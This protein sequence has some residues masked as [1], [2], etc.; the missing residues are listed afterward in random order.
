MAKVDLTTGTQCVVCLEDM[1]L[2]RKPRA[3][4][5]LHTLCHD[6]IVKMLQ[7]QQRNISGLPQAKQHLFG[8]GGVQKQQCAFAF[9][10]G[11]HTLKCPVCQRVTNLPPSGVEGLPINTMLCQIK[12]VESLLR[13]SDLCQNCKVSNAMKFCETCSKRLCSECQRRHDNIPAFQ[14]HFVRQVGT[15]IKLCKEHANEAEYICSVCAVQVCMVCVLS[16][17]HQE[18]TDKIEK[19]AKW[20]S[21]QR[22][23]IKK[24]KEEMNPKWLNVQKYIKQYTDYDENICKT[25][26]Q[27]K[28]TTEKLKDMIQNECDDMIATLSEKHIAAAGALRQLRQLNNEAET[29]LQ[30][31]DQVVD[32]EAPDVR[33]VLVLTDTARS[34]GQGLEQVQKLNTKAV[35][36]VPN[37]PDGIGI[38][39]IKGEEV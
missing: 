15:K 11:Q 9:G 10:S 34:F 28:E 19:Y 30:S 18:H 23:K 5:C 37:E 12:E 4:A 1:V 13:R 25:M 31:C 36:F 33:K 35:S 32:T 8:H 24:W 7:P 2:E 16:G 38:L 39:T 14:S 17:P 27:I 22:E 20:M 29:F 3:L 6:C 21:V 26:S